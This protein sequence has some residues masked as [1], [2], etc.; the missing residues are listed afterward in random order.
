ML[1]SY[2]IHLFFSGWNLGCLSVNNSEV[3]GKLC[4]LT[5]KAPARTL[6]IQGEALYFYG[7]E[8]GAIQNMSSLLS[9]GL[10]T[11]IY[12]FGPSR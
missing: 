9:T 4:Q 10:V 8:P 1:S 5:W 12:A 6:S 2:W 11:K 7:L 3:L